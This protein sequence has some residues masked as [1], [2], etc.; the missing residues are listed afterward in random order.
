MKLGVSMTASSSRPWISAQVHASG[1]AR[2]GARRAYSSQGGS[3]S[4]TS[5]RV[6]SAS[7]PSRSC[8]RSAWA[9]RRARR[10]RVRVMVDAV[11]VADAVGPN[12]ADAAGRTAL[13]ERAGAALEARPRPADAA[14]ATPRA[15]APPARRPGS[16]VERHGLRRG[17]S[18]QHAGLRQ[19]RQ[20][21]RRLRPPRTFR[22]NGGVARWATSWSFRSTSSR[23]LGYSPKR[24]LC[25][26]AR[27]VLK[28]VTPRAA[29]LA[30]ESRW[31]AA[32]HMKMAQGN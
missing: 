13:S 14:G 27:H 22:Y 29:C 17:T 1:C 11:P 25:A 19:P 31:S 8:F 28:D 3:T 4:A 7:A 9:A 16:L 23:I 18:G 12:G 10:G 15:D 26:P 6:P 5:K 30:Q 21:P 2:P 32:V 20:Q 24:S